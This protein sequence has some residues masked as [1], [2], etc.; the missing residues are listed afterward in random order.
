MTDNDLDLVS[1]GQFLLEAKMITETKRALAGDWRAI[2]R[3]ESELKAKRQTLEDDG[4]AIA[5]NLPSYWKTDWRTAKGEKTIFERYSSKFLVKHF[6]EIIGK[7]PCKLCLIHLPRPPMVEIHR[8]ENTLLWKTYVTA[9]QLIKEKHKADQCKIDELKP[10]NQLRMHDGHKKMCN[11]DGAVNETYLLYS[12][13]N[14][15]RPGRPNVDE[16]I[17]NGFDARIKYDD[18]PSRT[19]IS[20]TEDICKA[21]GDAHPTKQEWRSMLLC[22]V[23]LGR[24]FMFNARWPDYSPHYDPVL[25][26]PPTTY[27]SVVTSEEHRRFLLYEGKQIYPEFVI[28]IKTS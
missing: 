1:I 25:R 27:D 20:F 18:D 7:L 28:K 4:R 21:I 6:Q 22:R 14:P 5:G 24:V 23:V 9:T 8:I 26:R 17:R 15:P 19:G 3:N 12:I 11:L 2:A 13:A 16:I 10:P